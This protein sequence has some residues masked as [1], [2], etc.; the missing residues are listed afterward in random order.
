[1]VTSAGSTGSFGAVAHRVAPPRASAADLDLVTPIDASRNFIC[2]TLCPLHYAPSLAL[3][4]EAQRLRYNQLSAMCSNEL[5]ATFETIFIG[6]V[7]AAARRAESPQ[8]AARLRA[9]A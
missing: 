2:P 1:M 4:N 9:F 5:F 3:L 7:L 8:E 6:A